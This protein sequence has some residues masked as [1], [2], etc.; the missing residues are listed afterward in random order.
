MKKINTILQFHLLSIMNQ[1]AFN[2][3][4]LFV[5]TKITSR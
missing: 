3:W 2:I 1:K 4:P 5:F